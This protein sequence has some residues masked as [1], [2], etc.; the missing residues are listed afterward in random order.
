MAEAWG[1]TSLNKD[2][3]FM[4]VYGNNRSIGAKTLLLSWLAKILVGITFERNTFWTCYQTRHLLVQGPEPLLDNIVFNVFLLPFHIVPVALVTIKFICYPV[5]TLKNVISSPDHICLLRFDSLRA[6]IRCWMPR[7]VVTGL[8]LMGLFSN[9]TFNATATVNIQCSQWKLD[10]LICFLSRQWWCTFN[11]CKNRE[12][13]RIWTPV[14]VMNFCV[15]WIDPHNICPVLVSLCE[16]QP[17]NYGSQRSVL[18][19]LLLESMV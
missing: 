18:N 9:V 11:P 17:M 15:F 10:N 13:S 5:Y 7:I 4:P 12:T 16:K 14:S 19:Y 1:I 3:I 2:R 8:R 6:C